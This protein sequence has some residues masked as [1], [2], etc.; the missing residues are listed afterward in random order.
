MHFLLFGLGAYFGIIG[1][2]AT[3]TLANGK[4]SS[5]N[6]NNMRSRLTYFISLIVVAALLAL[7]RVAKG[8]E[9]EVYFEEYGSYVAG[10]IGFFAI[11][12][13]LTIN[14]Q[15]RFEDQLR[16]KKDRNKKAIIASSQFVTSLA[17]QLVQIE[18]D[19]K[20]TLIPIRAERASRIMEIAVRI[21][22][23]L[24]TLDVA[25]KTVYSLEPQNDDILASYMALKLRL[26]NLRRSISG[27][28]YL[29][30]KGAQRSQAEI[31]DQLK[32]ARTAASTLTTC[33][34]EFTTK[35]CPEL[36]I[37]SDE[38]IP[39]NIERAAANLPPYE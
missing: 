19:I 18:N 28:H 2:M 32:W 17:Y 39:A 3:L 22:N 9:Y 8:T 23:V 11:F 35:H 24:E 5:F 15:Y 30:Q 26:S 1:F 36:A 33:I 37:K 31:Q 10:I 13:S 6:W 38:S 7:P 25:E 20:D 27:H 12:L 34:N 21:G 14:E 16:D 4:K 29:H